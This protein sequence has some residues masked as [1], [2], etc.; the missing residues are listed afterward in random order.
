M[1]EICTR[2]SFYFHYDWEYNEH[3]ERVDLLF[4]SSSKEEAKDRWR[5][6]KGSLMAQDKGSKRTS[7]TRKEILTGCNY[8]GRRRE[9]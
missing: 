6:F 1:Y 9:N 8:I 7:M 2:R 5:N 4:I 3:T